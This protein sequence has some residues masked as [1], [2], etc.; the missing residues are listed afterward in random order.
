MSFIEPTKREQKMIHCF[1]NDLEIDMEHML[2]PEGISDKLKGKTIEKTSLHTS[3]YHSDEN[4]LVIT[5]TDGTYISIVIEYDNGHYLDQYIPALSWYTEDSIGYVSGGEFHYRNYFKQLID[6]G[7]VK[8][9]D[10]NILKEKILENNKKQELREYA[11]Y[12]ALKKKFENYN[13]KE[14]YGIG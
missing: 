10:E 2:I 4:H 5:F 9:L 11:Q 3:M 13:P 7:A 12:E 6:I 14:K 8:P 1:A